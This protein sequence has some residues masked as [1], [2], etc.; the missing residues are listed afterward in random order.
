MPQKCET[1]FFSFFP[2]FMCVIWLPVLQIIFTYIGS[3]A[4][5]RRV[6]PMP[7][8]V[9]NF[10]V[11]RSI[12]MPASLYLKWVVELDRNYQE[13]ERILGYF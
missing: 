4:Y 12:W 10:G 7:H 5:R 13:R 2:K 8:A 3:V 1:Y 11:L 9:R 6:L